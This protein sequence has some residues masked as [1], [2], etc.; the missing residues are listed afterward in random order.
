MPDSG[1][2]KYKDRAE[3]IA[4][5]ALPWIGGSFTFTSKESSDFLIISSLFESGKALTFISILLKR[6]VRISKRRQTGRNNSC[7]KN[8]KPVI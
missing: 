3:I 5:F 6:M 2:L 7:H 8:S 1:T 4:L